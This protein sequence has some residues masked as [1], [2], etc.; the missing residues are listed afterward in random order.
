M[1]V[2]ISVSAAADKSVAVSAANEFLVT[3]VVVVSVSQDSCLLPPIREITDFV[4]HV[5]M[6]VLHYT[7]LIVIF[8]LLFHLYHNP[9]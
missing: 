6:I 2:V 1:S 8:I 4:T 3:I 5:L 9:D 7:V